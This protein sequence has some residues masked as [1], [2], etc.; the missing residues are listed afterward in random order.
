MGTGEI[1]SPFPGLEP[2]VL[3]L[4]YAPSIFLEYISF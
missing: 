2:D 1:E 3:P 4:N